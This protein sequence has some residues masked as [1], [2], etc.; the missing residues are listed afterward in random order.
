MGRGHP[1]H[2]TGA[3]GYSQSPTG[4]EIALFPEAES[5][6]TGRYV[7]PM[8]AAGINWEALSAAAGGAVF[9]ATLVLA[10]ATWRLARS[11]HHQADASER[12]AAAS[13][14]LAEI[15]RRQLAVS[16]RAVLKVVDVHGPR[17]SGP[18]NDAGSVSQLL[19]VLQNS[20]ESPA[21]FD[22][23]KLLLPGGCGTREVQ[24]RPGK[25]GPAERGSIGFEVEPEAAQKA[26]NH[27]GD[28]EVQ[29]LYRD[30][31]S[32]DASQF[33]VWLKAK[34]DHERDVVRLLMV[35]EDL[36]DQRG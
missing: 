35:K 15:A 30:T 23:A 31:G 28:W 5:D 25:L 17:F 26:L 8:S 1:C 22:F 12:Q 13:A 14:E 29:I 4:P 6:C 3:V 19:V 11:A 32:T 27:G 10:L 24:P 34:P 21:M 18:V 16:S 9:L 20:G 7:Q 36:Q 2:G 33:R